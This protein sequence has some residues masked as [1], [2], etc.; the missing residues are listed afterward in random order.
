MTQDKEALRTL[1][2]RASPPFARPNL[3]VPSVPASCGLQRF[4]RCVQRPTGRR[5][6]A[7]AALVAGDG[8]GDPDDEYRLIEK[9]PA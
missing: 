2:K 8:G 6:R 3:A 4:C 5:A 1:R 7:S 9:N